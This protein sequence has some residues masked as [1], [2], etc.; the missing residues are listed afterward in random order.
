M[1]TEINCNWS[2]T[3]QSTI[4]NYFKC[5]SFPEFDGK[6]KYENNG[7]FLTIL[8][9]SGMTSI[10]KHDRN[11]LFVPLFRINRI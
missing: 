11:R 5:S 6:Y 3:I 8:L 1:C 9:T 2:L 4:L 7:S 10:L